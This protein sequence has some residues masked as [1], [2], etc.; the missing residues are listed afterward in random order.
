MTGIA[1]N[2]PSVLSFPGIIE[3]S[4]GRTLVLNRTCLPT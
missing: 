2:A 3:I 1:D 4:I